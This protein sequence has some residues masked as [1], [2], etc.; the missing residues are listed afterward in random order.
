M[1]VSSPKAAR[2][3]EGKMIEDLVK[4]AWDYLSAFW[5]D[6]EE[7]YDDF[8]WGDEEPEVSKEEFLAMSLDEQLDFMRERDTFWF[9]TKEDFID[10]YAYDWV[11]NEYECL[12]DHG[13][14]DEFFAKNDIDE[15]KVIALW[16][17]DMKKATKDFIPNTKN[18]TKVCNV[19]SGYYEENENFDYNSSFELCSRILG[20]TKE[21]SQE[22]KVLFGMLCEEVGEIKFEKAA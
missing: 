18:I 9:P 13:D 16:K 2:Y 5:C 12:E 21:I 14:V 6:P 19:I 11:E 17:S 15:D 8:Y 22:D 10:C 7:A 1:Y 20:N 4:Y 3:V